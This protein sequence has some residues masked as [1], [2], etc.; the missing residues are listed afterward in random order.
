MLFSLTVLALPLLA[1]GLAEAAQRHARASAWRDHEPDTSLEPFRGHK[2]AQLIIGA[3]DHAWLVGV[4][5]VRYGVDTLA[6]CRRRDC[7]PPGLDCRCGFY[8]FR[9]RTRALDLLDRLS[10]QHPARSYVVLTVDLDGSVLEYERGFR[11]QRQRVL[12]IELPSRC[13]RCGTAG[14]AGAAT[15]FVTHARFRGE[16]LLYERTLL[17]RMAMPPGSAPLRPLCDAHTP[18][19]GHCRVFGLHE[20]RGLTGTE[21]TLLRDER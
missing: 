16:Q 9:S 17:A 20:L 10:V 12:R 21:V 4:T 19:A 13:V 1:R 6:Q 7:T 11:A 3:D 5:S 14:D 15:R 18:A 2:V 8:A